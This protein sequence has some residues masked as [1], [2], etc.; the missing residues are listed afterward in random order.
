VTLSPTTSPSLN[1]GETVDITAVVANDTNNQGV[2]WTL[3]GLG[4]L[5]STTTSGVTY[6]APATLSASSTATVTATSVASS[7]ATASLSINLT[8]VLTISTTSLQSGTLNVPY[9]AYINA[10]G[11]TGP[12]TWSVLHGNLPLGLTLGS[13]T[14]DTVS[15]SGTPTEL[16]NFRFRIQV[17]D[18]AGNAKSQPLSILINKPPPL[19]VATT[20]LPD[21]RVGT[22]YS[23]QLQASS[24][25]K[26]YSWSLTAGAL[27]A[28]LNISASGLI[29]G[30]P[31][32][33]GTSSFT[34]EVI[35][36]SS[37]QQKADANLSI[38]IDPSNSNNS[39]LDGAYAF[40]LNG[41]DG[42]G[43]YTAVGSFLADGAGNVSSGLM[44]TNDPAGVQLG[45]TFSGSY[46]LG[47][48]NL[49]T[50]SLSIP[51]VGVRT[52]AIALRSSNSSSIIEVDALAQASGALFLQDASAFSTAAITG[53]YAFGFLGVDAQR[54]RL[55]MAGEFFADGAGTLSAG[56]LDSDE[57]GTGAA[58][59]AFSGSYS[60]L[61]SGRGTAS[62]LTSGQPATNYSLYVV[63]ATQLLVM[64]ID[65]I[66][67]QS[68]PIVSGTILQQAGNGSFGAS[69]LNG[70]SVFQTTALQAGPTGQAQVGLLT[71]DGTGNISLSSDLNTAGV[72]TTASGT[73]TYNVA[74]TGRVTLTNSGFQG[75]DPVLYLVSANQAFI[76]GTDA[77][78]TFGYMEQQSGAPFSQGSLSGNYAGAT[79]APIEASVVQEAAIAA[80]D[81]LGNLTY[82]IDN[83]AGSQNQNLSATYALAANGRVVVTAN[84][85]TAAYLYLVSP[86]RFYSLSTETH[87]KVDVFQQ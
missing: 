86:T 52:F 12:F 82:T 27:P 15:I 60:V 18:G 51:G 87:P 7:T 81:G 63:S 58:N 43:A 72:I 33:V 73:G 2:T 25:T 13:S 30:T 56:M 39:Q 65:Q 40:A 66:S 17:T 19:T 76:V 59:S 26:P 85:T 22:A 1:P 71:T 49:G 64:E 36:S 3:S 78:V 80:S 68:S 48:D 37:P 5:S 8:A 16:G 84:G 31:T 62:I 54:N 47:P 50:M 42:S 23:Q 44:D 29:S 10:T 9:Y 11:A 21:G 74:P 6:T 32:T 35:D 67:G 45:L 77:A 20:F 14:T 53:Y 79:I 70:I 69:S 55:G 83:S 38:T 75:S 4:S 61:P 46:S 28:G 24:G 57:A 34:V 41:F